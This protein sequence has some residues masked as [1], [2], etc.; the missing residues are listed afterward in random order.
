MSRAEWHRRPE[1]GSTPA[2]SSRSTRTHRQESPTPD[3]AENVR[4]SPSTSA[5]TP[6]TRSP[7][8]VSVSPRAYV[9]SLAPRAATVSSMAPISAQPLG[10][11]PFATR[12]RESFDPPEVIATFL[13]LLHFLL[14]DRL[15]T[16][17]TQVGL[18]GPGTCFP[19]G[20]PEER[21]QLAEP[22][23]FI[24][25]WSYEAATQRCAGKRRLVV[26]AL[27]IDIEAK[28]SVLF[29]KVDS[30]RCDVDVPIDHS[31]VDQ[32]LGQ[33]GEVGLY[34]FARVFDAGFLGKLV[35]GNHIPP[36]EI[37]DVP[38]NWSET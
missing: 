12:S 23:E 3:E 4:R 32:A 38:P 27:D 37:A 7:S 28:R 17:S 24:Q 8:I 16:G 25:Q 10:T 2:I 30:R 26:G 1:T 14:S 18:V 31:L 22:G 36:P 20:L 6:V 9:K 5:T 35:R 11:I 19:V 21:P 15:H 33:I 13:E 29:K 34:V